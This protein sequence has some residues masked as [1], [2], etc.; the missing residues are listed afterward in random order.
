MKGCEDNNGH[1]TH[2]A[3]TVLANGG[4]DGLGVYGVAPEADLMVVKVCDKR[5]YCYGDDIAAGIEYAADH[6][7]NIISMSFGGDSPDPMVLQA[8]DHAVESGVLP[9]AAA[10]ND[11]PEDGSIDYPAA[12]V[13]VIAV[14]AIDET[15]SVPYW[16]SRG[17][18]DGDNVVEEKEVEFAAPGVSIESAY[19]DGCY[20][21]MS[22]TSM[23]TPHISGLAAK[24]WQGDSGNTRDYI[25]DIAEDIAPNGDDRAS[26]LGLPVAP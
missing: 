17:L 10:G 8:I 15:E 21:Y 5:G 6:G 18:N 16:S 3:G 20:A 11:G 13:K 26:G 25:H 2:V 14:G 19:N 24:L 7:A 22:G 9:V 4:S 23:A 1:G 12:Y